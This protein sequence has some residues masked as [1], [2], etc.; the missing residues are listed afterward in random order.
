MNIFYWKQKFGT[1]LDLKTSPLT[2]NVRDWKEEEEGCN[3]DGG[4][5]WAEP[6]PGTHLAKA[7]PA[8]GG[9]LDQDL[10]KLL[11]LSIQTLLSDFW[12]ERRT[13]TGTEKGAGAGAREVTEHGG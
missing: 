7:M 8:D 12:L 10:R 13:G 6:E 11:A 9:S 1:S 4:W 5:G 3:K 2:N